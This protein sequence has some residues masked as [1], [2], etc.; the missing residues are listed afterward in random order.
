MGFRIVGIVRWTSFSTTQAA[1]KRV[2]VPKGYAAVYVGDKMRRFTIPVS[3]L[4]EPSF[5]ELL[6]QAE[7]E[8]G[9]H[10]PMGGL[11]IP[12]KEEEFLNCSKFKILNTSLKPFSSP[13]YTTMGFR[14]PGIGKA[15]KAVD[16][17]KGYLAVYVGEKMKRFVIP[18]SY[19]N[20]PSFQDLLSQAEEEFGYDHPMGGLTIPCSEDAFQ[21]LEDAWFAAIDVF[22]M[23]GFTTTKIVHI[24]KDSQFKNFVFN[25]QVVLDT[26]SLIS[27]HT[28]MG[29][30]LPGIRKASVSEIQASSKAVDVEKGYLAVY[31][32]EKMR[33]F[34]IPISYLNKPSFQD[35]L[36]QAEEEFGYHHPNRGL[37]IPCSEDPFGTCTDFEAAWLAVNDARRTAVSTHT[38]TMGFRLPGIRKTSIAANQASSK[39]VEVPKG[40]LVVYVGDKTKWFVI[41]VSYLNQPSFQD[42]LNQAEE[43]FGYDHPMGGLT[44]PCKEDE[45]LT[46]KNF[47]FNLQVFLDTLSLISTHTT[48]GFRL[49]GIRKASFSANQ[50]SSKAVDV[51]KGYLAVY[52]GEK[53]RRFVIPVSYLNKPSFQ[54]LLSQAEEEFGYHHPNGGLTIPC[55]EDQAFST[56]TNHSHPKAFKILNTFL[57]KFSFQINTTMGFRLPGIRKASNAVDAPK[58][59]LAVYVGEKMKRFVIPVSYMNQPSFQDLL[60]QA[61]EEFGYD[62]PMGGLTI[63]C[64]EEVFQ[65]FTTTKIVDI[66]KDSQFKNSI[67]NLQVFLDTLSL[68]STHTTMGFRLPGIRKASVSANQ[69]SSKAVDVEK[70]YLAVYV[71]EKMRRFVIPISYLNKPSFQDLL[72]QAEEEF[73]YHHPNGG[74]T[75]P[76]SED[77]NRSYSHPKALEVQKLASYSQYSLPKSQLIQQQWTSIAANQASSKSV[78]VPKGYLVVYVGDKMKRFVI[79]VSYLNQPSFQDLLNQAEEEFGYDHPMGGLTIPCKEDEFLTFKN[80]IFNLQVFLDTL[81]LISTHTTM[82]FR[83]PGIRK[84]SFSANQ[85]SSKAVDVEKGYLAVYV[86]EKMRRFVIPESYLNKP[87][88][89]DLLSQAEEEFGY[90]HP[91]GGL[92]IPCSEDQAFSTNTNHSHPKAFKMLNTFLKKFSSQIN[93]TMGF[94]LPGIRKAS[95]AVDAPKGYLAVYVGEKMKRFVIPVSYMNQPSFQ[96]LLNQA[97]EE[98]GYDHPMG[99]LTIPCSE[100]EPQTA[101]VSPQHTVQDSPLELD[102]RSDSHPKAFEVQKLASYSQYSLPKSQLIQ[103]EWT[104]IA[105]NQASSKSVEVPKGYLVVYVGDKMRRFV[106]PVSYLN[107]PSFQDLLNQ[108]EEEFGYDHPM[109]GLTIPCKEDEFLT[110][111]NSIFNLQVFLD[112]LSLISTHTTMG[113]RLPGIRKASFSANQASSKAV[114]VEKGYLAVYVG[115][116]MRRFVIPVSYLNKPSFQDLLS[117]AEEEF[118]YHH[119][120]GGLTIPCSEDQAFST[121]TNHSHPKAFK[122]LNTFL[123]K[124]S[125]QINTTMGFR[126]PGIRKASNAVDAPKG[127]LAVYVGE[128]MKRFVIPV[129]YMNQPSF[130]DL[131]TQAEEEFGYD[132]PMG[133]LTIPCSEEVFQLSTHTTTMGFR[134]PGIRK[135]SIAANQASSKSVEVPKGYLVVYVGDKMRRFLI[136]VSYLNQPSFQDLLNQAEEEFGYDHPMG[137]LTIP[138][139]EDE[140][141]TQAFSTN[142]NHSHPKAFKI[143]NTFLKKFSSQINTTMGFRLPGI[144]KASNAVDVP[145]GYLAVYVGEKMKRFVIPVSYLNQP[146]FQDLLTRAEEEFGYDHPMG[147]LTIPCSEDVFQRIT[148]CLN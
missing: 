56:N 110:F 130:Q 7:E 129:S 122:I 131:L 68:I 40:Y 72:S 142:T 141:L 147:G 75:I 121:N 137:G 49:P 83:L 80:F 19:L 81:S 118:G 58:G 139:K 73:G 3:Y 51:E 123:K 14:L 60:T 34:V 124:F 65:R 92:T 62:H 70:G 16:A 77:D 144:R 135:T 145:K 42:L 50:A 48:M 98:F 22:L 35:L 104:S 44:I 88:L 11:T 1:S 74:L 143:L 78:E 4:N 113:F 64:S 67:F 89:Q 100:E 136:P 119:P 55:S 2:D 97:E 24:L 39:S 27:T 107:Q 54:D 28:T 30:R 20:Q 45:F 87:S 6:S 26:L 66:L 105:A 53:M 38:T 106:I 117:Q 5:Q 69:A 46:F 13:I 125:S 132:H 36:S 37:T 103:Q 95:N 109:G 101:F 116:K 114:D 76:C 9:Y 41:P 91:N 94:R 93:T 134:L 85:A 43:E 148:C 29:F 31:V 18:V 79:P 112:T 32:G 96:D 71:G 102:N 140:F 111:K 17:P 128:K 127:Y 86:G 15:S 99:G 61:E 82:G 146:S 25:L 120:N 23:P 59:Y 8:F 133:G 115:E 12:Y 138:C 63:P 10:H 52:V 84:A 33:R 108:A 90:H 57:K 126:L 47:I 21:P